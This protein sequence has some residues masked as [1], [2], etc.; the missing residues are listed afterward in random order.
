MSEM[1]VELTSGPVF[2]AIITAAEGQFRSLGIGCRLNWLLRW[3]RDN[4]QLR[5]IYY[6][7][8]QSESHEIEEFWDGVQSCQLE[9]LMLDGFEFPSVQKLPVGLTELIL[10]HL[11]DV[12]VATN[13]ILTRLANLRVLS[14]RLERQKDQVEGDTPHCVPEEAIVCRGLRKVWWTRSL[15][16]GRVIS[17]VSQICTMLDSLSPPRNVTDQDLIAMSESAV[18]L[19]DVWLMDCPSITELGFR[20]LKNLKRLKHLQIHIHFATFVT[21]QLMTDFRHHCSTLARLTI[22]FDGASDEITRREELLAKIP[23]TDEYHALLSRAISFQ[24]S[25]LGDRIII[26]IKS[27]HRAII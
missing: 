20:S 22:V 13:A 27:I 25:T 10:T 5:E 9:K 18:W 21:E 2:D 19:M 23:G 14:L 15:G 24:P 1:Q 16:P 7:K 17:M 6:T 4:P 3:I 11:D 26:N 8:I 12:V